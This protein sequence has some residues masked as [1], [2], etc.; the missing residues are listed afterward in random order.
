M[1]THPGGAAPRSGS[2]GP[3]QVG[4]A[5]PA[6]GPGPPAATARFL[7]S[8]RG[9]L[10]PG[11]ALTEPLKGRPGSG[12]VPRRS[13]TH[14]LTQSPAEPSREPHS[15]PPAAMPP[16]EVAGGASRRGS[17]RQP[18]GA[19]RL[20]P[21]TLPSAYRTAPQRRRGGRFSSQGSGREPGSRRARGGLAGAP[22]APRPVR[23]RRAKSVREF[24]GDACA[25]AQPGSRSAPRRSPPAAGWGS[26]PGAPSPRPRPRRAG[27]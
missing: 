24:L 15:A 2:P 14:A 22:G 9:L 7:R 16:A 12:T 3:A 13:L 6:A 4:P 19:G 11:Q 17:A 10:A 27:G 26:G 5:H 21:R 18:A 8:H 23:G 25:F 1:G 20:R